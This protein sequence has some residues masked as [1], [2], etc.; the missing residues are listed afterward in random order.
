LQPRPLL[1]LDTKEVVKKTFSD[2]WNEECSR[3]FERLKEEI[4]SAPALRH[5]N[6][7]LPFVLE[8]D[9]SDFALGA[10]L[11]QPENLDSK[12]LHPVAFASRKLTKAERNYSTYDKEL[13]C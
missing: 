9:A 4:T 11:L 8:T 3:A 10:V 13:L 1:A 12:V 2:C 7:N 6:F 5:V